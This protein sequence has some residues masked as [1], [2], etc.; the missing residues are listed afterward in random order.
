MGTSEIVIAGVLTT[1]NSG[2]DQP[3][4]SFSPSVGRLTPRLSLF[5]V[6]N[7]KP[8]VDDATC[9]RILATMRETNYTPNT[10][11]L[12]VARGRTNLDR[13]ADPFAFAPL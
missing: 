11:A 12:G 9:Q 6:L 2:E 1:G 8:D 7:N 3:G 4:P 13:L 10:V 5:T